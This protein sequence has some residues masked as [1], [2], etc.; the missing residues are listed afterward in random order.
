MSE[1]ITDLRREVNKRRIDKG[2]GNIDFDSLKL[3]PLDTNNIT[4][5]D[6][7]KILR[8]VASKIIQPISEDKIYSPDEKI[9][10]IK[11]LVD[12]DIKVEIN[13]IKDQQLAN[14]V[15]GL[16]RVRK[17][18]DKRLKS[19]PVEIILHDN[20]TS[21]SFYGLLGFSINTSNEGV[22]K[23]KINNDIKYPF[24]SLERVLALIYLINNIKKYK[25]V[26]EEM[27]E[28]ILIQHI[29]KNHIYRDKKDVENFNKLYEKYNLPKENLP[30]LIIEK[31][32]NVQRRYE[33]SKY[34]RLFEWVEHEI[35]SLKDIFY[36]NKN[37]MLYML[38]LVNNIGLL[39]EYINALI[40][41]NEVITA[42]IE[43]EIQ[44]ERDYA[45]SYETKKNIPQKVQDKMKNTIFLNYFGYVEFDELTDLEK[46][47]Q[48]EKEWLEFTEQ[49]VFPIKKDHSLRF[50]RLGK[51]KAGG[52]YFPSKKA[53]CIDL[54]SPS[55]M[56]HEIFHMIDFTTHPNTCLSSIYDFCSIVENYKKATNVK[57]NELPKEDAFKKQWNGNSKYNKTYYH[58]PKEIF[59]RCGE[60][61]VSYTL[62]INTS[63]ININNDILYPVDNE[64]LMDLI[65]NY[66]SKIIQVTPVENIEDKISANYNYKILNK[67]EVKNIL[68]N[69]QISLF[70]IYPH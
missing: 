3:K 53:V 43:S 40:E 69:N 8:K 41:T 38:D 9:I 26:N 31:T 27:A 32:N 52:L 68:N 66:Y 70:E 61:Y 45:A 35:F 30:Q 46:V 17:N 11:N 33:T 18:D 16:R 47:E 23:Y 21:I 24:Y 48:I 29:N 15:K 37:S 60:M 20:L 1:K 22:W 54:Q 34:N 10:K 5:K 2:L 6:F 28:F 65:N 14:K 44:T 58:N 63:L 25:E 12:G 56:I 13:L 7:N 49:I 50:K 19:E 51:H 67:E 42:E 36:F 39:A 62:K 59:A 4:N 64:S 57:I 55:S